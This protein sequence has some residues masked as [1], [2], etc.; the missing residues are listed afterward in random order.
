MDVLFLSVSIGGGHMRA[1]E[2]VKEAILHRYPNSRALVV[3]A[4][5]YA[6]P[7]VEKLIV[8]GYLNAVKNTPRIYEKLYQF[9]ES[10]KN[11]RDF[12]KTFDKL[13][14]F[15]I[16]GLI[17]EFNPDVIVCTHPAALF[18]LSNYKRKH[19]LHIPS[20]A[21]LT[22]FAVHTLWIHD[23]IS[24]YIVAHEY[25]K[26]DMIKKGIPQ[27]IIHPL[28]IPVS[29]SFLKRRDRRITLSEHGL[30]DIETL[31]IMGGSLGF[32]EI[33][34]IF[35][36]LL[37]FEKDIQIIVITGRNIKL[38][39]QLEKLALG[40]S[41]KVKILS[42]TNKVS[43]FMDA[44]DFLITKPGG[45]TISEALVKELPMIIISPIPGQEERNAYFLINNG[46]AVRILDNNDIN[47]VLLQLMDN[48][49]RIRHMKEMSRHL[50]RPE[51]GNAIVNLLKTLSRS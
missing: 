34:D 11:M 31:L 45:L 4:L 35:K 9:S 37:S 2:A 7:I 44:A 22:D 20:V 40:S 41:K 8:G 42:Y 36:S 17:N 51:A 28:G 50:A 39:V 13:P 12:K 1:A 3:D 25:M 46:A 29:D 32:G 33:S 38:K 15:K 30:E 26:Q 6:N 27:E 49:L 14:S 48:P 19:T 16:K 43:D 24:A 47:D 5:K 21:L 18:M 10:T 23:Y